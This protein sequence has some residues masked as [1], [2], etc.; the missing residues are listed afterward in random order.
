MASLACVILSAKAEWGAA[1]DADMVEKVW[2]ASIIARKSRG[3][4][5]ICCNGSANV[6]G[7]ADS[8]G[9]EGT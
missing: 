8:E 2:T 3:D 5:E 4:M 1:K 7:L 6:L 9:A